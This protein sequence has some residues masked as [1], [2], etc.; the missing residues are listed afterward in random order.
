VHERAHLLVTRP[1]EPHPIGGAA[2]AAVHLR[3]WN[4]T[5]RLAFDLVE[6]PPWDPWGEGEHVARIAGHPSR[7]RRAFVPDAPWRTK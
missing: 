1:V 6:E 7:N 2:D 4:A 3:N 5:L